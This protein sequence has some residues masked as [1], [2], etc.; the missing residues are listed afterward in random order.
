MIPCRVTFDTGR[1]QVPNLVVLCLNSAMLVP[2]VIP[3]TAKASSGPETVPLTVALGTAALLL[4]T[5]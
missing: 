2:L 5:I 3:L 1:V 4:V